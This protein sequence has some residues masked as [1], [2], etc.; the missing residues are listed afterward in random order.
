MERADLFTR[1][2]GLEEDRAGV[3]DRY[4]RATVA[5]VVVGTVLALASEARAE[6]ATFG[7]VAA[8]RLAQVAVLAILVVVSSSAQ[9]L[10]ARIR[11]AQLAAAL[12]AWPAAVVSILEGDVLATPMVV[13][14]MALATGALFP[15]GG[16]AQAE[17]LAVSV[18]AVFLNLAVVDD[19]YSW[20]TRV[21]FVVFLVGSVFSVYLAREADRRRLERER[22]AAELGASEETFR[23][24]VAS[25]PDAVV[26]S[27]A[28][29]DTIVTVNRA[30]CDLTG[31]SREEVVGRSPTAV[32]LWVQPT[33]H[34]QGRNRI[35]RGEVISNVEAEFRRKDGTVVAGLISARLVRFAG[36]TY[37]VS[38]VRDMS[39]RLQADRIRRDLLAMLSHDV[40]NSLGNILGFVDVIR[41]ETPGATADLLAMLDRIGGNARSALLLAENFVQAMQIDS[42]AMALRRSPTS[43]EDVVEDAVRTTEGLARS[44]GVR[45]VQRSSG[46]NPT[47]PLDRS[48]IGRAVA[49]LL[50]NAVKY[51]PA[52]AEVTIDS[53]SDER[54]VTVRVRD[55]GPGVPPADRS[56][57]FQRFQHGAGGGTGLGLFIVRSAA[58]AHGGTVGAEFPADGGSIFEISLPRESAQRPAEAATA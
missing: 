44:R 14:L 40:K 51:S 48:L 17:A 46:V 19:S 18:P 37:I 38:F 11:V 20:L 1:P 29:D 26:L 31:Y 45:I 50:T 7:M 13:L 57:L 3:L 33:M 2:A 10:E 34:D 42:G 55:R 43:V 8:V 35:E 39:E 47:L 25:A 49:N 4:V 9:T 28:D 27:R 22:V 53:V 58:D 5:T 41:E 52:N 12:L 15:W 21:W 16:R 23:G 24:V 32:G 30:F 56:K 6:P 54:A 36:A